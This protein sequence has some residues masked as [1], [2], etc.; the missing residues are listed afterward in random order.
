MSEQQPSSGWG[1]PPP[2]KG[3]EVREGSD[4]KP[5]FYRRG[6]FPLLTF[7]VGA[8][9]G[10]GIVGDTESEPRT[11]TV[12]QVSVQE[13]PTFKES[14]SDYR[15]LAD[16]VA[17]RAAQ[18][19]REAAATTTTSKPAPTTTRKPTATRPAATVYSDGT[20]EVG[21]E[22]KPGTYKTSGGECYWER[23]KGFSG[24]FDDIIANDNISG[25]SRMTIRPTDQGVTFSGGCEWR[26]V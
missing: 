24:E 1:P 14:C 16:V 20:Y 26:K 23:L 5:P 2:P 18:E 7:L 9:V 8:V 4:S 22:I 19:K 10:A 3:P 15:K 13:I 21:S 17:C 12:T 25:P 11:R 6:W